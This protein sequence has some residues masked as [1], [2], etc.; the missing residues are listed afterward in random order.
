M[1]VKSLITLLEKRKSDIQ[2]K[3]QETSGIYSAKTT[4]TGVSSATPGLTLSTDDRLRLFALENERLRALLKSINE[5]TDTELQ[6]INSALLELSQT[7]DSQRKYLAEIERLKEERRVLEAKLQTKDMDR[8]S[9]LDQ[10]AKFETILASE[11]A[12]GSELQSKIDSLKRELDTAQSNLE[13]RRQTG[14]ID[15]LFRQRIQ[16]LEKT[17][18]DSVEERASLKAENAQLRMQIADLAARASLSA[19]L[20]LEVRPSEISVPRAEPAERKIIEAID[21][22]KNELANFQ[23]TQKQVLEKIEDSDRKHLAASQDHPRFK[24][25]HHIDVNAQRSLYRN[26]PQAFERDNFDPHVDLSLN[27]PPDYEGFDAGQ[28]IHIKKLK[29]VVKLLTDKQS[30]NLKTIEEKTEKLKELKK[31]NKDLTR[32]VET[33]RADNKAQAA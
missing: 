32:E 23:R 26:F 19:P 5:Q 33:L 14:E 9:L 31:A 2:L 24:T 29:Q 28:N 4:S 3:F 22:V 7:S 27:M 6:V 16:Q 30:Q 21:T 17:V 18:K 15:L 1:T 10:I 13:A 11:K 12:R 25:A 20:K 8:S